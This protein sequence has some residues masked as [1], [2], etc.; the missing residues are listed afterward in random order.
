M[1]VIASTA[2]ETASV[3]IYSIVD[4]YTVLCKSGE[5][6]LRSAK[7]TR[8]S[9]EVNSLSYPVE[10]H[11]ER[12]RNSRVSI[13]KRAIHIR[14]PRALNHAERLREIGNLKVWAK[15]TIKQNPERF[16]P[17]FA[18]EYKDGDILIVGSKRYV[19]RIIYKDKKSSSAR[20]IDNE[21]HLS[22]SSNLTREQPANNI[23]ALLSRCIAGERL[24]GLKKR[25]EDLNRRYFKQTIAGIYFKYN[26]SNWGSCS[27]KGN[28]NISTRLLF[29][30]ED[31]L[32]YVCTHELA[33]LIEKNH[34][35]GFW[36]LVEKAMPNYQEQRD[37]LKDNGKNCWF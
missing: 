10:I 2:C 31:V 25:I 19:L 34:S 9:I 33:H 7:I 15:K 8:D 21:I 18:K 22:I 35:V 20:L 27:S 17:Q 1:F 3:C 36:T 37:W 28:I 23:S 4:Y 32:G 16:E 30:P 12:R 26:K 11:L 24:P 14:L 6:V 5:W 29:A 13:G